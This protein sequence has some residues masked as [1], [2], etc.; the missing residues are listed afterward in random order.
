MNYEL[1]MLRDEDIN[2]QIALYTDVFSGE[3][4]NDQLDAAEMELYFSRMLAMNSFIGYTL[5]GDGA[6]IGGALGFVRP[7]YK[8]IQY[9]MDSFYIAG[10]VQ[11]Q[12][13]GTWCLN[14]ILQDLK[15]RNIPNIILDTE[16][17]MPSE[18][19]Y[20]KNGFSQSEN[21]LMYSN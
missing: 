7:W 9:H 1:E 17:G 15:K 6:V 4:W 8:G 19:F 18:A 11:G 2:V 10:A 12:G 20:R 3:P 13:A 14:G 5:R 16:K 21:I